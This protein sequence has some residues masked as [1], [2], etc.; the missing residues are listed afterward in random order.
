MLPSCNY[1]PPV[2]SAVWNF[3]ID[4]PRSRDG[5]RQLCRAPLTLQQS[6]VQ[7]ARISRANLWDML[8][9]AKQDKGQFGPIT[10]IIGSGDHIRCKTTTHRGDQVL[11][12]YFPIPDSAFGP[13]C[14]F[15]LTVW[16]IIAPVCGMLVE[17]ARRLICIKMQL[18]HIQPRE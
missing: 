5:F 11:W 13:I 2:P 10:V 7:K 12:S 15:G 14:H 4:P 8:C 9:S 17:P 18:K 3:S 1:F 6:Q 16:Q